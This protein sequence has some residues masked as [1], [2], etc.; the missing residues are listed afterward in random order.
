MKGKKIWF[1]GY[2]SRLW[3]PISIEGWLVTASFFTGMLFIGKLNAA[4]N[5]TSLHFSQI[6]PILIEFALLLG[7]LYFLT[8][9]HVDKRY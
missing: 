1:I 3:V 9:G 8:K 6:L 5:S 4:S 2:S 7:I